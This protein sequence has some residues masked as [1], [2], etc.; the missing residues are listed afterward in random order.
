[1]V[2]SGDVRISIL[3]TEME[4]FIKNFKIGVL[5]QL[6]KEGY[7]TEEQLD[8]MIED[9]NGATPAEGNHAIGK[10]IEVLHETHSA[11]YI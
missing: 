2:V 10:D 1:M 5:C 6:Q 11:R 3:D 7:L 8:R 9:I 4:G